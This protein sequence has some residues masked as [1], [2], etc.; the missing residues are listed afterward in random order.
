MYNFGRF[1]KQ[2]FRI[3]M[4]EWHISFSG[5]YS[6]ILYPIRLVIQV[7]KQLVAHKCLQ[8]ASSLA[9]TAILSLA[10]LLAV[11]FLL[12]N[13][14]GQ[15]QNADSPIIGYIQNFLPN[16]QREEIIKG[17]KEFTEN[18]DLHRIGGMVALF[19]F[20]PLLLI[21][22]LLFNAI[23]TTFNDIW[24][25]KTSR[26]IFYKFAIFYTII[27]IGPILMTLSIYQANNLEQVLGEQGGIFLKL[28]FAQLFPFSLMWLAFLLGYKLL[29][30]TVVRW[31]P[32]IIGSL[33]ASMLIEVTKSGFSAY[34]SNLVGAG[35][36][37]FYGN[38]ALIPILAMWIYMSWLIVLFGTEFANAI[39]NLPKSHIKAVMQGTETKNGNNNIIFINSILAIKLFL[40]VAEN[41]QNGNAATHKSGIAFAFGISEYTVERLFKQYKEEN[42]ILEVEGDTEGYIPAR[43]LDEIYVDQIIDA[44]EG[45]IERLTTIPEDTSETLQ[46]LAHQLNIAR[47]KAIEGISVYELLNETK[48]SGIKNGKR[49]MENG[50]IGRKLN[51]ESQTTRQPGNRQKTKNKEKT[52]SFYL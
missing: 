13:G 1:V 23:E 16:Y 36:E 9:F 45:K 7:W 25:V 44:F 26:P 34:L 18:V 2:L 38:L 48:N 35:Y 50:T 10:P 27:T 46:I 33:I 3:P 15:L 41:F 12:L 28:L 52:N 43:P 4:D 30:N 40:K 37:R 17:I 6:Y 51:P 22:L 39:Q 42:L 5:S 32:V 29:P 11:A 20:F 31:K 19:G 8:Q 21:S 14:F 49:K 24:D 47:N